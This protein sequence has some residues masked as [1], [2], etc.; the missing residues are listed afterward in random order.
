M[1][2]HEYFAGCFVINLPERTDRRRETER[3]LERANIPLSWAEFF[4]AIRPASADGFPGIGARGCFLSHLAV[5]RLA[6]DRKWTNVLILEDDLAIDPLLA[7]DPGPVLAFLQRVEWGFAYLGHVLPEDTSPGDPLRTYSGAIETAHFFALNGP[8]I[9]RVVS[10]LE[11]VLA[12]P[13]GH[14]DGGPMHVDGAYSTFRAQNP[15]V[16]T[17]VTP[18]T[19]GRQRSSRSD[20]TTGWKDRVF[21]LRTLTGLARSARRR[22]T[23]R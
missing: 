6:R 11:T 23:G 18:R 20:I 22:L 1:K 19:L 15:S 14:P 2:L 8:I 13:P 17:L 12:R 10:F 16:V 5:L 4:P 7:D 9:P 3:E 21:G